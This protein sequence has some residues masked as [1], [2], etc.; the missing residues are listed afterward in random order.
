MKITVCDDDVRKINAWKSSLLPFYEPGLQEC[1]EDVRGTNLFF[2]NDI[3]KVVKDSDMVL[4]SVSTPLKHDGF[5]ANYAPDLL[6]SLLTKLADSL[7][8]YAIYQIE[9]GAQVIQMFDS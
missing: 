4:V 1:I 5:G 7:A 8:A 6:H 2:D 9:C 3:A